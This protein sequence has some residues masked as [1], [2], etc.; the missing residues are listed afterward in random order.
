MSSTILT[1]QFI[2]VLLLSSSCLAQTAATSILADMKLDCVAARQT[3]EKANAP[4]LLISTFSFGGAK[5]AT[6][7]DAGRPKFDNILISKE[8]DDCT[9]LVFKALAAGTNL[10]PTASPS[11][12][13]IRV[14]DS[15]ATPTRVF[16]EL[17]LRHVLVTGHQFAGY[18]GAPLQESITLSYGQIK[19]TYRPPDIAGRPQD[20]VVACWDTTTLSTT[21][22]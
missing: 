16:L 9:P 18:P 22:P 7:A 21:C 14:L 11:P 20:P 5:E 13:K 1:G 15:S 2:Y 12:V 17:E 19:M 8:V 10:A 4:G 3:P 6:G